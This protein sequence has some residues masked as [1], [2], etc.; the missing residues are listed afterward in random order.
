LKQVIRATPLYEFF[1]QCSESSPEKSILDCGA[2]GTIPPLSLFY[3]HSFKTFGIEIQEN[4]LAEAQWYCR[5]NKMPLNIIRGDMRA[6]PFIDKSFGY[7]YSYNAIFFM[8]KPDIKK[9]IDEMKRVLKPGGLCFVNFLSVD[10]PDDGAFCDTGFA[11]Q[12]LNSE[13]FAKFEDNEADSYFGRFEI[14]RKEKRYLDKKLEN[15]ERLKQVYIDFI[16]RKN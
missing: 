3:Q 10:D 2:G 5:E 4:A 7:V 6:I 15:G 11:R 14:L 12:L 9:S 13:R 16:A 8:T 1:R